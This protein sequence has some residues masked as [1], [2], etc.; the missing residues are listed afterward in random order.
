MVK[1]FYVEDEP[2]LA[3]IVQETLESKGYIVTLV[4]DGEKA[5][6]AFY[7][8]TFDICILDIMLPNK[9]GY[10][11]AED[12]RKSHPDIPIL[13]LTAKDQTADVLKG[14]KS[15]GNDYIRKPFSMEELMARI[16]N[17]VQLAKLRQDQSMQ[18]EYH[19]GQKFSFLPQQLTLNFEEDTISLSHRESQ[20]LQLMCKNMNQP[21]ERKVILMEVWGDDSFYNSRNLDVYISKIRGYFKKDP[22]IEIKTLKGVGY[23]FIIGT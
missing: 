7:S 11:I 20:I 5:E 22:T 16:D 13:F 10:E 2:F 1:V 3:K 6:Q 4:T 17:F 19:I 8:N 21:T 14:F 12:I 23:Q 15:G 18:E 9:N